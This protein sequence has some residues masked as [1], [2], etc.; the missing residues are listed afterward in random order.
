M[1]LMV[2]RDFLFDGALTLGA[3]LFAAWIMPKL[4]R[5]PVLEYG[6]PW[7]TMLRKHFWQG[8][9]WGFACYS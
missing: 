6:F 4:E 1:N 3:A 8:A 2:A 5:Q 9:V 7:R